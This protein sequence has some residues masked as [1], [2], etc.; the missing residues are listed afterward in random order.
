MA[1]A[2]SAADAGSRQE[3]YLLCS[4]I[5]DMGHRCIKSLAASLLESRYSLLARDWQLAS[6]CDR[7]CRPQC[8]AREDDL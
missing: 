1:Q 6:V 3:H 8:A 5:V 4:G 2:T 7:T